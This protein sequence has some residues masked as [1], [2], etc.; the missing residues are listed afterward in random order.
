VVG[1]AVYGLL[2]VTVG[3]RLTAEQEQRGADRSIHNI[4]ANPEED[5]RTFAT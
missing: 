5:I 3:I 4:R 1:L 2:K